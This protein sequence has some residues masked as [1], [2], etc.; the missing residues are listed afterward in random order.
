[1]KP[2]TA[3]LARTGGMY[4]GTVRLPMLGYYWAEVSMVI[5]GTV[6]TGTMQLAVPL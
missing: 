1:M 3:V 5:D 6:I 2:I 4:V